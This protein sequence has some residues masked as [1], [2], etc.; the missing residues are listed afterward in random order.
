MYL[1]CVQNDPAFAPAW[2][3]LGRI[4]RLI[5]KYRFSAENLTLAESAFNRALVLNPELSIADNYYAQLELDLGRADEAMVRLLRRAAVRSSSP[6]LFIAL[7]SACR[8]CGLLQPS[9]AAHERARR[10]DPNVRTSVQHT[11]FTAGDYLRAAEISEQR[12]EAGN[13]GGLALACAG[14]PDAERLMRA[15]AARYEQAA[16]GWVGSPALLARDYPTLRA[17]VD[18]VVTQFPDPEAHFYNL[19]MLSRMGDWDRCIEIL[20]GV[21]D[22]GFFPYQTFARHAW[23]DPARDRADFKAVLARARQRQDQARAAYAKA[24]GEALL[25]PVE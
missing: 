19:L 22:R 4:Y 10:L 20:A 9:I 24:G 13:M 3:R 14:H 18:R 21:V 23:L 1:Q 8:Y 7:V 5:G 17:R 12:W 2:A 25:G 16:L 6:D 15:E 11:Y